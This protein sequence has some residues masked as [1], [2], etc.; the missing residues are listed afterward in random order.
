M[1]KIVQFA[2]PLFL[3]TFLSSAF[4]QTFTN[5]NSVAAGAWNASLTK[6]VVVSGLPVPLTSAFGL[7]NVNI[8]MGSTSGLRYDLNNYSVTLTSPI[9][10]TWTLM[11]VNTIECP[12]ATNYPN[13][14]PQ[15]L[16][17]NYRSDNG[18]LT[19]PNASGS[20][21]G[22][23]ICVQN[24]Y[25][26]GEPWNIGYYKIQ[27]GQTFAS[28]VGTNPNGAWTVAITE[29]GSTTGIQFNSVSLKFAT[30]PAINNVVGQTGYDACSGAVCLDEINNV[31]ATNNGFSEDNYATDPDLYL[32]SGCQWNG[33]LNNSAWFKFRPTAT[34]ATVSISGLTQSMQT[35]VVKPANTAV[36]CGTSG[37]NGSGHAGNS[38]DWTVPTGGSPC[39]MNTIPGRNTYMQPILGTG[40]LTNMGFNLSGLTPNDWYF[41]VVDG[42]GGNI[43]PLYIEVSGARNCAC[44]MMASAVINNGASC[45][46][47]ASG[48]A[49]VTAT[50]GTTPLT[51]AWDNG[52]TTNNPTNLLAGVHTVTVTDAVSCTATAT[53]TI[54]QLSAQAIIASVTPSPACNGVP[55]NFTATNGAVSYQWAGPN[56][57]QAVQSPTIAAANAGLNN[58]TYTVTATFAGNC[59]T[60]ATV[61]VN[62]IT[63]LNGQAQNNGPACIGNNVS[64]TATGGNN[65]TWAGPNGFVSNLQNPSVTTA[66][67]AASGVYS[68]TVT[69]FGACSSVATTQV[70]VSPCA[71]CDD[72]GCKGANLMQNAD[73]AL[74]NTGF[75]SNYNANNGNGTCTPGANCNGQYMCQYGYAITN[76]ATPCNPTWSS[77][78]QDHTPTSNGNF[79]LVDFPTGVTANNIWCQTITLAPN[80][81]Y[82]MGGYFMNLLPIG[83]TSVDPRFQFAING[84]ANASVF[85]VDN[86][87]QW[88]FKGISYNSGAG[89]AVT[90]CIQNA[91]Y[92]SVG[93]DVALDDISVRPLLTGANPIATSDNIN[94]CTPTTSGTIDVL[95]NDTGGAGVLNPSS[96]TI[97]QAPPF[98]Q[99]TAVVNANNTIT[100]TTNAAFTLGNTSF[101][102]QVCNTSGC[103]STA[104]VA[105]S[106]GIAPSITTTSTN[107]N[108]GVPAGSATAVFTSGSPSFSWSNGGTTATINGLVVGTYT[109]T[110]TYSLGCTATATARVQLQGVP[111]IN[112][113]ITQPSCGLN[114]GT[115]SAS[116]IITI[117]VSY[118][119]SNGQV[120]ANI[121]NLSPGIY[122]VTA[123][124]AA[125]PCSVTASVTI[126]TPTA[127]AVVNINNVINSTCG[128]ANGSLTAALA[129]GGGTFRWSNGINTAVNANIVAGTYTVTATATNGCTASTTQVITTSQNPAITIAQTPTACGIGGSL[130][131]NVTNGVAISA[132]QWETVPIQTTA[133]ITN[134]NIGTTYTVDV[135]TADGCTA[136][137]S[138]VATG[139]PAI[140]ITMPPPVNASCGLANGSVGLSTTVAPF[141]LIWNTGST[142]NPYTGLLSGTYTATVTDDNGCTGTQVA[143]ITGSNGLQIQADPQ[144]ATCAGNDGVAGV[145]VFGG[146]SNTYLW[147]NNS[148][149]ASISNLSAGNYTVTVS[150]AVGGTVC[151]AVTT[152]VVTSPYIPSESHTVTRASC[153][154]ANGTINITI[155][156]QPAGVTYTYLWSNGATTS[157][158]TN[159]A[160]NTGSSY[161]VTITPSTG[162]SI[163][164]AIGLPNDGAP[165]AL[166][167]AITQTSCGLNNGKI[168][169]ATTNANTSFL[170]SNTATD[171]TITA[172][173]AGVYTV[174]ATSGAC[175]TTASVTIN[176]NPIPFGL[177]P[178]VT[179]TSCG[180]INGS[181]TIIPV[182]ISITLYTYLWS[183]TATTQTITNIPA[184][185]YTV[186]VTSSGGCSLTQTMTVQGS[187]SNITAS[188]ATIPV[189]YQGQSVTLQVNTNIPASSYLWSNGSTINPTTVSP[190]GSGVYTVTATSASGC[191]TTASISVI[192]NE[193]KWNI[194]TV[195]TPNGDGQNDTFYPVSYGG[196]EIT[197]FQVYNRWGQLVH[198]NPN[199]NWDGK[200]DGEPQPIDTY[201]FKVEVTN[202]DGKTEQRVGDFLLMR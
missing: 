183:N 137:A 87:E 174:T 8:N 49:T 81:D 34:T 196:L 141:S 123:T 26:L 140:A 63:Q 90:F 61:S 178:N 4:A 145:L 55:I 25:A 188:F 177:T 80:T 125:L 10:T 36:L 200:F 9:G 164:R 184:G 105:V 67:A 84:A 134:I 201:V 11:P 104:S 198:N 151:S 22:A 114:N 2:L 193:V 19:Y 88:Q 43:S 149:S 136:T 180:Q 24:S 156:T 16:N 96:V 187:V 50:G 143:T 93:Y 20:I 74:G 5:S 56:F 199:K 190:S 71:S 118:A 191:A 144:A 44:S 98:S 108:C 6:Q 159:I 94:L 162:C 147:S 78:I 121:I 62:V 54:A 157:S 106:V 99:G 57:N 13:F 192:V 41:L 182:S 68:V 168:T 176:A 150:R 195:F 15:S 131:M 160:G 32:I 3:L 146:A 167:T 135:I 82:C 31:T 127:A 7:L 65:Y 47:L 189:I 138:V 119:W 92:G 48:A 130:T 52:A 111:L 70:T 173:V 102:Y 117:G 12:G 148:T 53:V 35:I 126:N 18:A 101:T 72:T 142:A 171:S 161:Y 113:T 152:V 85:S 186:T 23:V 116:L 109:I 76:S 27:T 172:L 64:L 163:I 75:T 153:G 166:T 194:P 40:A 202:P 197:S 110:A 51:Y 29:T 91:N 181:A 133:T 170:W 14:N 21:N 112:T 79:M 107:T 66:T 28:A 38:A 115:A 33:H 169:A 139:T 69:G 46:P 185:V 154:L 59:T 86:D 58:G 17:I 100:F 77:S 39:L 42:V 30:I 175:T 120:G 97:Y 128:A 103:C 122:T 95:A 179:N 60:T 158:I 124:G 45:S 155:N 73:F 129:N 1:K 132:L 83:N 165:V 89:G 37:S